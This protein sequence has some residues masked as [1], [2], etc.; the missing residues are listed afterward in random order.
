MAARVATDRPAGAEPVQLAELLA[1]LAEFRDLAQAARSAERARD[2]A[3]D[4]F[5]PGQNRSSRSVQL[6]EIPWQTFKTGHVTLL[7]CWALALISV[8]FS[9]IHTQTA[10]PRVIPDVRDAS[11]EEPC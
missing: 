10:V 3:D 7:C 2:H 9:N 1:T 5:Y 6:E 11:F 4:A 8:Q